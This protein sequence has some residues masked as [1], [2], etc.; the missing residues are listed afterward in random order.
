MKLLERKALD[1]ITILDICATSGVGYRT[2]FRHHP[3]KESLL[4]E[5]AA[6]QIHRLVDLT[7]PVNDASD[8]DAGFVALFEYVAEHR[9][10]WFALL[11]GGAAGSM[12]EE[13]LRASREVATAR[14]DPDRWPPPDLATVFTV[15]S[16]I[17]IITWWLLQKK[18]LSVEEIAD[19]HNHLVATPA[20]KSEMKRAR[21]P[22]GKAKG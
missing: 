11:T 2:F 9:A 17:E 12:R 21:K 1:Q 18:P 4:D 13:F 19:I 6:E 20:V 5:I 14:A 10:L 15:T 16:T 8:V 7:L 22:L 3:S